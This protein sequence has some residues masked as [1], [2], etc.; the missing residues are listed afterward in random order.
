MEALGSLF[1]SDA[2]IPL[3]NAR[4]SRVHNPITLEVL[5]LRS[6]VVTS[7]YIRSVSAEI[8]PEINLS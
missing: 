8:K 4:R 7:C 1:P 2:S 3:Y 6:S 5:V